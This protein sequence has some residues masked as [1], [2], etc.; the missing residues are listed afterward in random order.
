[1]SVELPKKQNFLT[2]SGEIEKLGFEGIVKI[3]GVVCNFIDPVDE[4]RFEGRAQIE[5]VFGQLRNFRGGIIVR[6]L[7]DP[8]TNF[9]REIQAGKIEVALFELF[10]DTERVQIVI[11]TTAVR[12]H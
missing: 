9:K 8:F 6:M 7:D 11:E 12:A 1:M 4:L 2:E 3:C 10:D 5:K